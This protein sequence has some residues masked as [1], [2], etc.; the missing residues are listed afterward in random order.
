MLSSL[1]GMCVCVSLFTSV[2]R[3]VT[4]LP[5]Q[6]SD[7]Y[8]GKM[9]VPQMER[10]IEQLNRYDTMIFRRTNETLWGKI[11]RQV[12]ACGMTNLRDRGMLS[13]D[14]TLSVTERDRALQLGRLS[15]QRGRE[16]ER[17]LFLIFKG[18]VRERPKRIEC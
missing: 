3:A 12:C 7:F 14:G 18:T 15:A 10:K 5:S 4:H 16:P 8:T 1:L 17:R 13:E 9:A 2:I 11:D 6:L